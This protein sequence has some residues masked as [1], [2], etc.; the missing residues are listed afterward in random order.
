MLDYGSSPNLKVYWL[1]PEKELYD[2]LRILASDKDALVMRTIAKKVKNFDLFFNHEGV[3]DPTFMDSDND[4]EDGDDDL[5]IDHLDEDVAQETLTKKSK[6]AAGSRLGKALAIV[7]QSKVQD[8][9]SSDEEL[10]LPEDSD[11]EGGVRMKFKSFMPDDLN[12]PT[13]AIG[14]C[15]PSM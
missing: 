13:F 3:D 6:K 5:F 2:G 1:L 8:V 11:G 4:V 7:R 12:S 14:M 9:D 10:D 15:F